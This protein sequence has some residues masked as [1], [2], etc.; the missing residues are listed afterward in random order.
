MI[1]VHPP[2]AKPS[3]PPPGIARLAGC[4]KRHGLSCVLLDANLEAILYLLGLPIQS[5]DT[6]TSR[7]VRHL[8]R[9]RRELRHPAGYENPDR[10]RQAVLH[11]NRILTGAG[12]I[13]GVRLSLANY[14]DPSL[15]P[16]RSGDL[17]RS[18][19]EHERS[20]FHPYFAPRLREILEGGEHREI[21]FS[22][23]YLS[24]ALPTFAMAGYVRSR[25]PS[26]R[27]FMGGGLVG[28]WVKRGSW[29]NPF[30]GLVDDMVE[31]P[32]EQRL[33]SLLGGSYEPGADVPD[34]DPFLDTR[35]FAPGFVLPFSTSQGCYWSRCRFCPEEA[36]G[37]GY[38]PLP[39]ARALGEAS[40]LAARTRA[41]LV[42]FVDNALS[43][44]FLKE[45]ARS[46]FQT[47]W[48]GFVR[49]TSLLADGSFLR[50]L[51][52]SGCLML[53]LGIESGSQE[54]LDRLQKGIDLDTV[55]RL[56]KGLRSAGIGTYVYLLFGTPPEDREKAGQTLSFTARHSEE[57]DF[58][59]VAVFNMPICSGEAEKYGTSPFYEADLSLYTAFAHPLGW[60]RG[61]VRIFLDKEFI[62]HPAIGPILRRDPPLFTS[63]HAPFFVRSPPGMLG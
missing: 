56:L 41:S 21:G 38:N 1:L 12:C 25:Y 60:D 16:L 53:K 23:N 2:V 10:Y 58:L 37:I 47:P 36:E 46:G 20:L 30:A 48:Y 8:S 22:L 31:G 39:P 50:A 3:E 57:I 61:A 13:R 26:V 43:P 63:N 17:L 14:A 4:L 52:R 11:L 27:I 45:I 15:S 35:Y 59:N 33:V 51:K 6:W 9:Y 19:E 44:A 49:A 42:H 55:S 54:V 29:S 32:G 34:Y 28:S 5:P 62:R 24:Q 7:A 18:A 40:M